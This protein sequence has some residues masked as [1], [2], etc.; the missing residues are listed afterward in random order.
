MKAIYWNATGVQNLFDRQKPD[1]LLNSEPLIPY[2]H[3]SIECLKQ[4]KINR[5]ALNFK[6]N[7]DS[8]L[9][10]FLQYMNHIVLSL[11]K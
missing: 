8:N 3:L 11:S 5:F 4:I 10:D 6:Y 1:L 9:W 7:H 2:A